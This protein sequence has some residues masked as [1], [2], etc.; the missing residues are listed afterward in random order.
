M[1]FSC[2]AALSPTNTSFGFRSGV[3]ILTFPSVF[4]EAIHLKLTLYFDNY[5][6]DSPR[7]KARLLTRKCFKE[8]AYRFLFCVD[9]TRRV[10]VKNNNN[11]RS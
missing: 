1:P 5:L 11:E 6:E 3:I 8:T 9:L 4:R 7:Q 10:R 2:E